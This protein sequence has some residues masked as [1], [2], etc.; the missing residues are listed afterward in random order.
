MCGGGS[1]LVVTTSCH[2]PFLGERRT[3]EVESELFSRLHYPN[4]LHKREIP[5]PIRKESKKK[6]H[7]NPSRH[8]AMLL[9][10]EV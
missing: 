10:E 3:I 2:D 5:I 9:D 1:H 4:T 6:Q 8:P 7:D